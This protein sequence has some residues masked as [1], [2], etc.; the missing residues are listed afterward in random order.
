MREEHRRMFKYFR[1]K[2]RINSKSFNSISE[3]YYNKDDLFSV[4][5]SC[6]SDKEDIMFDYY[7]TLPKP[8]LTTTLIKTLARYPEKLKIL[9][10]SKVPYY[11]CMMLK[12]EMYEIWNVWCIFYIFIHVRICI[13]VIFASVSC[14]TFSNKSNWEL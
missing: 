3:K 4:Q 8:M 13:F 11:H 2:Y 10:P 14:F 9:K 5:I 6:Y 7:L 1:I 12:Y